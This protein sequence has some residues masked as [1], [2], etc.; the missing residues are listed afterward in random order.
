MVVDAKTIGMAF[1]E[2]G[3][4][5][6]CHILAEFYSSRAAIARGVSICYYGRMRQPIMIYF[7]HPTLNG[8]LSSKLIPSGCSYSA[9]GT[10]IVYA[11]SSVLLFSFCMV[12]FA[13]MVSVTHLRTLYLPSY[14]KSGKTVLR[15]V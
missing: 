10:S 2:K 11:H 12:D 4:A 7:V 3:N 15:A 6:S 14:K 13:E 1:I 5:H 9:I 8:Q